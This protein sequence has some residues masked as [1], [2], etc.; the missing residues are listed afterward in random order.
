MTLSDRL[1]GINIYLVGMMGTGKTTIGQILAPQLDY[2]FFDCDHL[3]EKVAQTSIQEIFAT[4]GEIAFR[5]LET[6]ILSQLYAYTR[7]VIATGGGIVLKPENWSYLR[8]GLVIWLDASVELLCQRLTADQ[9]RP[10]LQNTD[11]EAKLTALSKQRRHLY[12]EAD[13]QIIIQ[14]EQTPEA[15][16]SEILAQIPTVLKPEI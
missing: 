5:E 1:K 4:Q 13:L 10:L 3:L 12:A 16:A 11:L 15:I 2:R 14:P 7:S 8:H 6:Q 9:T